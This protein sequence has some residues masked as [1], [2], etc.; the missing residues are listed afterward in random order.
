[1][2]AGTLSRPPTGPVQSALED[3][4][5]PAPDRI[6]SV[7]GGGSAP[8]DSC[9]AVLEEVTPDNHPNHLLQDNAANHWMQE[10]SSAAAYTAIQKANGQL[11]P[12]APSPPGSVRQSQPQQDHAA[13]QPHVYTISFARRYSGATVK[14]RAN[15]MGHHN[16]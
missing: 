10:R 5:G 9:S 12:Q 2:Q 7:R 8:G 16:R 4:A 11:E 1:M 3:M 14:A 15:G 6:F 13:S